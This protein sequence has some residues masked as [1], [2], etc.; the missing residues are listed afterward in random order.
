MPELSLDVIVK[1]LGAAALLVLTALGSSTAGDEG[2]GRSAPVRL[3]VVLQ[4]MA[5]GVAGALAGVVGQAGGDIG[6]WAL[7]GALIGTAQWMALRAADRAHPLW[8]PA[9]V[10]GWIPFA[11]VN[12]P[13][14][15][16]ATGALAALLQAILCR[17]VVRAP[18]TWIVASAFGWLIGG[19]VGYA[20]GVS[21]VGPLGF[22]LAWVAGWT[23][24]GL[25]GCATARPDAGKSRIGAPQPR[26]MNLT[27]RRASS[28]SGASAAPYQ[29]RSRQPAGRASETFKRAISPLAVPLVMTTEPALRSTSQF[30]IPLRQSHRAFSPSQRRRRTMSPQTW[31]PADFRTIG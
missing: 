27:A 8:V 15:W 16:A 24:V 12:T 5:G 25:V 7:F 14:T 4:A 3:W 1:L 18:V 26:S 2:A 6:S 22:P 21:L 30:S 19:V 23:I 17:S 29:R 10:V 9:S 13:V 28:T 31:R 20:A 11:L